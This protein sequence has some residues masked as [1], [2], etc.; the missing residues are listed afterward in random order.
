[1]GGAINHHILSNEAVGAA[2][3]VEV[4]EGLRRKTAPRSGPS[5]VSEPGPFIPG[6]WFWGRPLK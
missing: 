2:A 4:A 5:G 3:A 6:A 1:M